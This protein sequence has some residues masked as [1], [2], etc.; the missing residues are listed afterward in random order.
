V[1]SDGKIY[2]RQNL[3]EYLEEAVTVS[4]DGGDDDEQ[5]GGSGGPHDMVRAPDGLGWIRK[6][7]SMEFSEVTAKRVKAWLRE[8]AWA[9]FLEAEADAATQ[10]KVEPR[11]MPG[12][13]Y[14]CP[15]VSFNLSC[16][17]QQTSADESAT[18]LTMTIM[19]AYAS[20]T[21]VRIQPQASLGDLF[22]RIKTALGCPP[23][24]P[25]SAMTLTHGGARLPASQLDKSLAERGITG[26]RSLR[27]S[28]KP[29]SDYVFPVIISLAKFEYP[30]L[31][32]PHH[33]FLVRGDVTGEANISN[34]LQVR[35]SDTLFPMLFYDSPTGQGQAEGRRH[36]LQ[37]RPG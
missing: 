16:G 7:S 18:S 25:V 2:D 8:V 33:S 30:K 14:S 35:V 11:L 19:S 6:N 5:T 32:S 23:G 13:A 1:A 3:T 26:D 15:W 22:K 31:K 21:T 28:I 4:N 9:A 37:F 17:P 24:L 34:P 10:V 12:P 27:L 20:D 29:P 36:I